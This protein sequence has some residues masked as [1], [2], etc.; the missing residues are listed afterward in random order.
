VTSSRTS[1]DGNGG[2]QVADEL[3]VGPVEAFEELADVRRKALQIT[4][5]RLRVQG[6]ENQAALA[7]AADTR[8]RGQL[9]Q[10]HEHV[11]RLQIVDAHAAKWNRRRSHEYSLNRAGSTRPVTVPKPTR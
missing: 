6:I 7:G 11:D 9:P 3:C 1:A 5:L 10:R 2:G 8:N 4:A